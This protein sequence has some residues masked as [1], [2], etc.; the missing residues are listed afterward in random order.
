MARMET[1]FNALPV[2]TPDFAA[3]LAQQASLYDAPVFM[4]HRNMAL[5]V[6]SLIG[7]L[8]LNLRKGM[9]V[10][11]TAEGNDAQAAVE[12]ICKMLRTEYTK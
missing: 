12:S 11:V 8:S 10:A 9:T 1:I 5:S 3:A 4:E 7:I 2:I 6:D